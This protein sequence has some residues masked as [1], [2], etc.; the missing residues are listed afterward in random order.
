MWR[1]SLF[2]ALLY[3]VQGSA[4]AYVVNFQKPF[5]AEQGVDKQTLGLFTSLLLL[6]FIG[7]I[8]LGML[9]DRIPLGRFGARKPYM[10]L[11]L[12]LFA[13]AYFF[14]SFVQPM[15]Q[16]YLFA[17]LSWLASLGLAWFDTC[18]DGWAID[19]TGPTEHGVV[20]AAMVAGK[21]SGLI[22]MSYAFGL[23]AQWS[24]FALVFQLLAA[25][26]VLVLV[27][28]ALAPYQPSVQ[29]QAAQ[30]DLRCLRQK[31]YLLFAAFGVLYSIAS[32]GAD[33][34]VTLQLSDAGVTRD[35]IGV[36]GVMRGLGALLG[37]GLYVW[38]GG[39]LQLV[40]AQVLA[41]VVLGGG[42]LLHVFA[43]D[44]LWSMGLLWGAAW[45]FQETAYVTL[46]MRYSQGAWAAT[47]FALSMIFS[48]IGT[49]VGEAL[50]AP[51][52]P[53]LGYD[54]VFFG[55]AVVAWT[56]LLLVRPM[57]RPLALTE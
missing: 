8:F 32:F 33:G 31:S 36:Y 24:G 2:F 12:G 25:M 20:Q 5:L 13:L 19:V 9:S 57:T 3:F 34:M 29:S 41:L 47:L 6:P 49:A 26:A 39:R 17:T 44:S 1:K 52:V 10:L 50:G 21:A 11:G 14:L 37:A 56:C 46:A 28:V 23:L 48:N 35:G 40:R 15:E 45:G 4:L 43:L 22:L 55:F 18:V 16:F 27:V 30:F 38:I 54:G 53:Q 7:K 51:L 42:C